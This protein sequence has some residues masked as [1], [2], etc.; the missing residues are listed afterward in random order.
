MFFG[1]TLYKLAHFYLCLGTVTETVGGKGNR[2]LKNWLC[3]WG[4]RN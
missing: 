4:F 3:W 1:F 2:H